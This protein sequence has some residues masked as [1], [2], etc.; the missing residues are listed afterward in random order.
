MYSTSKKFTQLIA[1]RE[2]GVTVAKTLEASDIED[3]LSEA[4]LKKELGEEVKEKKEGF[5][6]PKRPGR[7]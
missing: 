2:A 7:R 5:S 4:A 6:R 3:D 1:E